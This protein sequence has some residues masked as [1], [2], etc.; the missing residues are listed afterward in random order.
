MQAPSQ[1]PID[2]IQYLGAT[3]C[4]IPSEEIIVERLLAIQKYHGSGSA[5]S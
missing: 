4:V 3:S 5:P 2:T 1:T